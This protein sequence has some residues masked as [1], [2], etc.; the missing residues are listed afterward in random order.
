MQILALV[1][2]AFGGH[3]GIAKFNRDLLSALCAASGVEKVTALPRLLPEPAGALPA[4]LDYV[5]SG[6]GGKFRYVLALLRTAFRCPC[7][8][9]IVCGHINLLPLAFLA[10]HILKLRITNHQSRITPVPFV[11]IIHGID[12]WQPT[13]SRLLNRLA[14]KVDVVVAVSEFT[15]KKFWDWAQP[16]CARHFILPNCVD[17]SRF[18]PGPKNPQLVDRY[19]LHNRTVLLTL[20][21]LSAQERYKGIDEVLEVLPGL[22]KQIPNLTYLIVGDGNDRE[23]LVQKARALGLQVKMTADI[24]LSTFNI[25]HSTRKSQQPISKSQLPSPNSDLPTPVP[26][27][28]FT[29]RIPESEK[30]DHYRLADAFVM[31]GWGEGFGIVYLE[32]MACGVPVVAS[33]AD[34]SREVVRDGELGIAVDPKSPAEIR[35]GILRALQQKQRLVPEGLDR[36]SRRNFTLRVQEIIKTFSNEPAEAV[37]V[38]T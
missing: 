32:A 9:L 6:V 33:K 21:R 3:G 23:R 34:A 37:P 17:L 35:D 11:L 26:A 1:T 2:D 16:R 22:A 14:R 30:V 38:T 10:S 18:T 36:F 24:Q 28:I 27:V 20:A 15:R 31:P 7:S 5:T 8:A 25:Q 13:R 19:G 29:G 12:A 4:K